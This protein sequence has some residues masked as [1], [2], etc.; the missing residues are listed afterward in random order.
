LNPRKPVNGSS[1][2]SQA[3][4]TADMLEYINRADGVIY[5]PTTHRISKAKKGKPVHYCEFGCG[6]VRFSFLLTIETHA[7]GFPGL[8]QSR[9]SKVRDHYGAV[10]TALTSL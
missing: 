10:K 6:K 7:D 2:P 5:T 1:G 3:S 4:G 9:A 8:Y